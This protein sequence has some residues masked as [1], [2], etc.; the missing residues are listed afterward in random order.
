MR[1]YRPPT[2][3]RFVNDG[4]Q[5]IVERILQGEIAAELVPK[6]DRVH[7]GPIAVPVEGFADEKDIELVVRLTG[8]WNRHEPKVK[9]LHR[10]RLAAAQ[11]IQKTDLATHDELDA[12]RLAYTHPDKVI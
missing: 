2:L 9:G 7:P 5:G 12:T 4:V 11:V 6:L 1:R 3:V 8:L 10:V